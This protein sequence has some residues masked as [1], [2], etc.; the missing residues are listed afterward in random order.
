MSLQL[1]LEYLDSIEK[2]HKHKAETDKIKKSTL[3]QEIKSPKK[4]SR[5]KF[6]FAVEQRPMLKI[7]YR[8]FT[9]IMFEQKLEQ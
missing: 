7:Q 9:I 6:K 3:N 1:R 2:F 8:K 5:L 4:S